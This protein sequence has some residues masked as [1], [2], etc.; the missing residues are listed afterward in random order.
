MEYS[1]VTRPKTFC[2][3]HESMEVDLIRRTPSLEVSPSFYIRDIP[4]YGD[5][6]LAPMDGYSDWPFR[7]L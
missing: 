4:I 3:T 2:Y 5:A 1:T 7:S 6:I